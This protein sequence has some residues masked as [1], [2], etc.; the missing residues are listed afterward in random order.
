MLVRG[1]D[2]AWCWG[3]EKILMLWKG[4]AFDVGEGRK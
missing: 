4:E 3:G 2:R 1:E